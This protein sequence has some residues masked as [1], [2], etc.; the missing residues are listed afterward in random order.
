MHLKICRRDVNKLRIVQSGRAAEH[1]A[2][3]NRWLW[4]KPIEQPIII[5]PQQDPQKQ[6]VLE[7][8][9]SN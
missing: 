1:I 2:M 9:A 7:F 4:D 6:K 5:A 8:Q 3:I